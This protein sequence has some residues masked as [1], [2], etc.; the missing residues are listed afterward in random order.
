MRAAPALTLVFFFA[1]CEVCVAPVAELGAQC[2][3]DHGIDACTPGAACVVLDERTLSTCFALRSRAHGD[4]CDGV[5]ALCA[6]GECRVA[7]DGA[8]RCLLEVGGQGF[9]GACIDSSECGS[10]SRCEDGACRFPDLGAIDCETPAD[11][12]A[13]AN[14]VEVEC[15]EATYS[16]ELHCFVGGPGVD[17]RFCAATFRGDCPS[18]YPFFI[19]EGDAAGSVVCSARAIC[20]LN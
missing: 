19:D 18:A 1:A 14:V 9:D 20:G 11:C 4:T 12:P 16:E 15:A 17:G 8:E 10:G 2:C 3:A 7:D 13:A 5:S 6:E